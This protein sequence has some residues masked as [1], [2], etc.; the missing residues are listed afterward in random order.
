MKFRTSHLAP[1]IS[2]PAS[3]VMVALLWDLATLV[4]CRSNSVAARM[5][6]EMSYVGRRGMFSRTVCVLLAVAVPVGCHTTAIA[7]SCPLGKCCT[8]AGGCVVTTEPDCVYGYSGRWLAGQTCATA[9]S[10]SEVGACCI[11]GS[12]IAP[13]TGDICVR[14]DG[15]WIAG[16]TC[17]DCSFV[18]S[19]CFGIFNSFCRLVDDPKDCLVEKGEVYRPGVPCSLDQV[20]FATGACCTANGCFVIDE[21]RCVSDPY[22]GTFLGVGVTCFQTPCEGS[23][24]INGCCRDRLTESDCTSLGGTFGGGGT[25]CA[26]G[27]CG[28]NA[29]FGACCFGAFGNRQCIVVS[30]SQCTGLGGNFQGAGTICGFSTCACRGDFNGDGLRNTLD[31]NKLLANFG[32]T[33]PPYTNGDMNGDG[34]VNTLDLTAFFG[35]FG[36]PCP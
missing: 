17:A 36:I 15:T 5:A 10:P 27:A 25:T 13:I 19:C 3:G 26:T 16:G 28:V 30:P 8:A 2:R 7:Q 35:V 1:R 18:G 32:L 22:F 6:L 34:V 31:L 4:F 29:T 23:C 20:C 9:C 21:E 14:Y 33:V 11:L 12:C 24:C